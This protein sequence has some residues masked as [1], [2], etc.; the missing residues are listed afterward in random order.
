MIGAFLL[1]FSFFFINVKRKSAS[2]NK[3][4]IS[5]VTSEFQET[6]FN[7]FLFCFSFLFINN[8][9]IPSLH[10]YRLQHLLYF[11]KGYDLRC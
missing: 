6:K 10:L 2:E 7:I 11:L 4:F 3:T 8:V 5:I 9:F 1:F